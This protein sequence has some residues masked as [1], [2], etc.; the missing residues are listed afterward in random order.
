MLS[1][2][3]SSLSFFGSCLGSIFRLA[4]LSGLRVRLT[5]RL[6]SLLGV[7]LGASCLKVGLSL[8]AGLECRLDK[9][10]RLR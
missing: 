2:F 10:D 8:S 4:T 9:V 3:D 6:V 5:G 1:L 7:I